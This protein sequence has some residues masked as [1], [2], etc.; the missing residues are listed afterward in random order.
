MTIYEEPFGRFRPLGVGFDKMF[1]KLDH[2]HNQ[3]SGNY[4]PYNILK[5]TEDQFVVEIAVA[6][7]SKKD[8]TIDLKDG[9]LRI[10]AESGS[11][12]DD[13]EYIHKGIAARSFERIFALADHV[14]VKEATYTDGILAIKLVREIPEEEKPIEIK[15]K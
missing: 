11:K 7:F 4:P 14:K 9:S 6:G 5:L 12:E 15:I 1:E 13:R 8:F 3:P 2:L 10:K